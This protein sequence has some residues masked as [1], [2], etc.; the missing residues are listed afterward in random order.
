MPATSDTRRVK[1]LLIDNTDSFTW[2]L[3][4]Q[5]QAL[6][7]ACV[8]IGNHERT[9]ADI[10][11]MKPDRI[12]LSPGPH[13]PETAGVSLDVLRELA[14]DFP[15]LGVCLGHQCIAHVFGGTRTVGRARS[16]MHGKTS[17]VFHENES[18]FRG[19]PSP[20]SAARYHSLVVR[21]LPQKFRMLAW[22]GSEQMKEIMAMKHEELPVIGVQFHPESFLTKHGSS[23]MKNFLSGQ[24]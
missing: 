14:D 8:V 6:G 2:N 1:V 18:V 20:F 21:R 7:A 10:R 19:M 11:R 16:V 24:W 15:I 22:A 17:E 9:V 12:I 5:I 23:L 13:G 4:Q 3:A